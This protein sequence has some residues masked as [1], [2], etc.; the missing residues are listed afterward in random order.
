MVKIKNSSLNDSMS[1]SLVDLLNLDLPV[2]LSWKIS[3]LT[4]ELEDL[5]ILKK[6]TLNSLVEKYS[7]KDE[8]GKMIPGKD[9]TGKEVPNSTEIEDIVAYNKAVKDLN[10]IVNEIKFKPISVKV[11]EENNDIIKPAIFFNLS[12][13]F[14][15]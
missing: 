7:K 10:E 15:S 11:I 2:S 4:K 6:E 8:E 3:K 12:F 1:T 5:M 14:K 13:M 9:E